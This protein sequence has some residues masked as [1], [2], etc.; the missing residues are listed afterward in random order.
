MKSNLAEFKDKM[1][2][3]ITNIISYA[4]GMEIIFQTQKRSY[5][6]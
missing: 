1:F 4:H 3:L 6:S 5:I 2:S